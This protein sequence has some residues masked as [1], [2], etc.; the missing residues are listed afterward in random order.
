LSIAEAQFST[1]TNSLDAYLKK[2]IFNGS[3]AY[4][5]I[6]R[7]I[8]EVAASCTLIGGMNLD[9]QLTEIA[10]TAINNPGWLNPN[11]ALA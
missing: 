3:V 5:K 1:F 6:K 10:K 8:G 4:G 7:N 2:Y 11:Y 9:K